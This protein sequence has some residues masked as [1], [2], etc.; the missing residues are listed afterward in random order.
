M[1][2]PLHILRWV[3]EF[4]LTILLFSSAASSGQA[5]QARRPDIVLVTA[6]DLGLQLGCYGDRTV[7]TPGLDGLAGEGVL[8]GNASITSALCSPSRSTI[9]TGCYPHENGQFGLANEYAMRAGVPNLTQWLRQAG[10]FSAIFGKLH[11]RPEK[12]F[13][14]DAHYAKKFHVETLDV[15]K[16]AADVGD[17]LRQAG[18]RPA[19]LYI[20]YFDPHRNPMAPKDSGF[21]DQYK[22]YPAK[23]TKPEE[24]T[25]FPFQG[26]T[27]PNLRKRTAGY[28]NSVARLDAG[29]GLLVEELKAQGRW[30]NTLFIFLSDNGPEFTRAKTTCYEAGLQVP[31]IVKFPNDLARGAVVNAPVSSIDIVPTILQAVGVPTP[32]NLA[33]ESLEKVVVGAGRSRSIF[34][35][36]TASR[37]KYGLFPVRSIKDGQYKLIH[38]LQHAKGNPLRQLSDQAA[39][40]AAKTDIPA[41][42]REALA[43]LKNPPEYELYDL[44]EDPYE[45]IDLGAD[46]AK[47]EVIARLRRLLADWR[48]RTGDPITKETKSKEI[49]VPVAPEGGD[50]AD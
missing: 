35:E 1:T 2:S 48:S 32:A 44:A 27:T 18:D 11:V 28:Y 19:F 43:R 42:S 7:P 9:L 23:L 3:R 22:G 45:F 41:R 38:N 47:A 30:Q 29:I 50:A 24:V 26:F 5:E 31:F 17:A 13:E 16:M 39:D 40:E 49:E 21:V 14:F 25:P 6:D 15:K 12:D 33:G 20:N 37:A 10:Y 34:G 46:P 4:F 8:F 36:A